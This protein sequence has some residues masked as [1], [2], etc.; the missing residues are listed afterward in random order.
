M[1]LANATLPPLT[2]TALCG[3]DTWHTP[4]RD[5]MRKRQFLRTEQFILWM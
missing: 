4:D 2:L 3:S 1:G 5:E